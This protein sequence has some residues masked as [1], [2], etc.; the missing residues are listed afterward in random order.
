ML[1]IPKSW[2]NARVV[3]IPK[4]GGSINTSSRDFRPSFVL[5]ILER[6]TERFIRDGMRL[7]KFLYPCMYQYAYIVGRSTGSVL[8]QLG[9][10]FEV[11]ERWLYSATF[12][13]IEEVSH[14]N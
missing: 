3:F 13:D 11:K 7:E 1:H 8:Q 14:I 2:Y 5:K 6:L 9:R 12:I 4:P 10:A